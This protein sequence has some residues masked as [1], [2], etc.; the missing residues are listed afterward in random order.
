MWMTLLSLILFIFYEVT[1]AMLGAIGLGSSPVCTYFLS[2]T[3]VRIWPRSESQCFCSVRSPSVARLPPLAA[4]H[5]HARGTP[6]WLWS[7]SPSA[8]GRRE[9]A[10]LQR[11]SSSSYAS[12]SH[13]GG[14]GKQG[15]REGGER[16][17]NRVK[18]LPHE[19]YVLQ[20]TRKYRILHK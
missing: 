5:F 14:V 13:P 12:T 2:L 8:Y 15:A 16:R 17:E 11:C 6:P 3:V 18:E 10:W 19:R 20:P 7:G 9:N 4:P 1:D